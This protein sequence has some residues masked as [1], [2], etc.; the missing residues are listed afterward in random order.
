MYNSIYELPSQVLASLDEKDATKWM[1][2]YNSLNPKTEKEVKNA[3]KEA[4]KACKYLPS[5]F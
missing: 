5:S 1:E 3:K 2:V 4:W